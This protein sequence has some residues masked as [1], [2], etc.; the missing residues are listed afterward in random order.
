[1]SADDWQTEQTRFLIAVQHMLVAGTIEEARRWADE[2]VRTARDV[3]ISGVMGRDIAAQRAAYEVPPLRFMVPTDAPAEVVQT[4][5]LWIADYKPTTPVI[6]AEGVP[7]PDVAPSVRPSI[8]YATVRAWLVSQGYEVA[9][10]AEKGYERFTRADGDWMRLLADDR[11]HDTDT[12]IRFLANAMKRD[13][14]D[15]LAKLQAFAAFEGA[16]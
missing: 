11:R 5:P 3:A 14:A 4:I 7:V 2:V 8:P 6:L 12:G 13:A 1:M 10:D 9:P 15:V 16:S